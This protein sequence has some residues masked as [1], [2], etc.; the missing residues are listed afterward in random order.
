MPSVLNL[1]PNAV[2]Q[3]QTQIFMSTVTNPAPSTPTSPLFVAVDWNTTTNIQ[4]SS[5]AP[6]WGP[7]MPQEGDHA[8]I[9]S[10]DQRYFRCIWWGPAPSAGVAGTTVQGQRETAARGYAVHPL[11]TGTGYTQLPLDA[12]TFDTGANLKLSPTSEYVAPFTGIYDVSGQVTV[13]ASAGQLVGLSIFVNGVEVSRGE[14]VNG[15]SAS[16]G[17]S[18]GSP[19]VRAF[20]FAYNSPGISSPSGSISGFPIYQPVL[21]DIFMDAWV[22]IDTAWNG[23]TPKLDVGTFSSGD[24]AGWWGTQGQ[25]VPLDTGA[26]GAHL[27][28][29]FQNQT[30]HGSSFASNRLSDVTNLSFTSLGSRVRILPALVFD[31]SQTIKICV[32]TTG[33]TTGANPGATQGSGVVYLVTA[34][35][36]G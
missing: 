33:L 16:G 9:A 14:L 5:W 7:V 11:T 19:I 28:E 26:D 15:K 8:V 22:E 6:I 36:L 21:N 29:I 3:D 20:P 13:Q 25:G 27:D 18:A 35:P 23:T 10:D 4:V 32:S 31:G 34:T 2:A 12:V 24:I 30:F 1:L 17:G